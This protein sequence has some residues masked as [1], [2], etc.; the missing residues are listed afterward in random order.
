LSQVK[1]LKMKDTVADKFL[2]MVEKVF[3]LEG[4]EGQAL[5]VG[6]KVTEKKYIMVKMYVGDIKD[7]RGEF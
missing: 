7:V 3:K 1:Q 4:K 5:V 6:K 2:A